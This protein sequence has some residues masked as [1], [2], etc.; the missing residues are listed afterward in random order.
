MVDPVKHLLKRFP[1]QASDKVGSACRGACGS[2]LGFF[3]NVWKRLAATVTARRKE[4]TQIDFKDL[5]NPG[6]DRSQGGEGQQRPTM[7][8]P[9]GVFCLCEGASF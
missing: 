6:S 2:I 9:T 3:V 4:L 5:L 7:G 8:D 1:R